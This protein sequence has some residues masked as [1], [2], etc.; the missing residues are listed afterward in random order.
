MP[1][2]KEKR[3]YASALRQQQASQTR[4]RI[5]DA[6]QRLFTERG[7]GATTIES[8]ASEAGVATDT[9][10]A[11]F[12]TKAGVLH[13]L[14]DVRVG[15][16]D[17]PVPLLDREGPQRVRAEPTQQKQVSGFAADVAQIL[18]RARPVDDIMRGAAAIDPEIAALR[19]RMQGLRYSNVRRFVSWLA[20]KGPFRDAIS[21][22]EAGAIVW[23]L[24]SP[25]V[26]GLLRGG[27]GWSV[28]RYSGWLADTLI[29]TL[30]T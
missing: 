7:Y 23:T 5:L 30:L 22:E 28:E 14:L 2:V 19:A 1:R 6:A 29:R 26:H 12:G 18:E 3:P 20:A 27:R 10:Y 15:G 25:E 21:E 9:V 17:A 8:I 24:A 16:D 4:S 11:S 13:K